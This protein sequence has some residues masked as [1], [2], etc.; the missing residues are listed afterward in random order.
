MENTFPQNSDIALVGIGKSGCDYVFNIDTKNVP[1][2]KI[3][4]DTDARDLSAI[5]GDGKK[6]PLVPN[7]QGTGWNSEEGKKIA[8]EQAGKIKEIL[9]NAKAV[10]IIAALGRGTGSG[11]APVVAQISRESHQTVAAFVTIPFSNDGENIV[12]NAEKSR[13][14][15]R[16]ECHFLV[17]LNCE[18]L[19]E[20]KPS[21]ADRYEEARKWIDA[22][23]T[24]IL[25]LVYP[26]DGN[27]GMNIVEL[28]SFF[29]V[30]GERTVFGMGESDGGEAAFPRA[31]ENLRKCP[32]EEV[33]GKAEY[34]IAVVSSGTPATQELKNQ[35]RERFLETFGGKRQ[36]SPQFETIPAM[37]TKISVCVLGAGD[38]ARAKKLREQSL[39]PADVLAFNIPSDGSANYTDGTELKIG[40]Y[41]G[42]EKELYNNIDLEKPTF[43][44]VFK[45]TLQSLKAEAEKKKQKQN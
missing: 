24:R 42:A 35:V 32:L 8:R 22:G 23:V 28:R 45:K 7:G 38:I 34:L 3:Y 31:F 30:A 33:S 2:Q 36:F 26:T 21:S 16:E 10:I 19:M 9:G 12:K 14:I 44:R 15:L 37:G 20:Q 27:T 5:G 1:V 18:K 11:V 29:P 41:G 6:L 13:E 4:I 40:D 43:S 39:S 17:Q 25:S